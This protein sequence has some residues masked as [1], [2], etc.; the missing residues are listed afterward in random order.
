LIGA[1]NIAASSFYRM[2]LFDG[3]SGEIMAWQ[4]SHQTLHDG[5]F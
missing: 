1:L 3:M 4:M 2:I 5:A